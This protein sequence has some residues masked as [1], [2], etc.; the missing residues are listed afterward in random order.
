MRPAIGTVDEEGLR[1][2]W[3]G[4]GREWAWGVEWATRG[5]GRGGERQGRD[6]GRGA[7]GSKARC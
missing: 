3:G 7:E 5:R 2:V 1:A 4:G 6:G